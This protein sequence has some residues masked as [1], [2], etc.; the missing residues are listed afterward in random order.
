[1]TSEQQIKLIGLNKLNVL[2]R[3]N[4]LL[5]KFMI[6]GRYNGQKVKR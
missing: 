6:T 4:V 2:D 1:M 5:P 3:L